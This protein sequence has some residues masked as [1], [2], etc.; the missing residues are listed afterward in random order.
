M[1]NN[2]SASA[3]VT[4]NVLGPTN[5][6]IAPTTGS[7]EALLDS[8]P[9]PQPRML[10]LGVSTAFGPNVGIQ[11]IGS[12]VFPHGISGSFSWVQLLVSDNFRV[13]APNGSVHACTALTGSLVLEN[14]YPYGVH[15]GATN[16]GNLFTTNKQDDPAL[17]IRIP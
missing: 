3:A 4:F 8:S 12:A 9:N 7:A 2:E 17:R 15:P 13:L 16:K 1:N 14:V 5:P 6:L 11:M 10:F